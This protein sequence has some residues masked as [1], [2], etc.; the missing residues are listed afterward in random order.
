[1]EP[2]GKIS[3][4]MPIGEFVRF[5]FGLRGVYLSGGQLH[6]GVSHFIEPERTPKYT[7]IRSWISTY[8]T[9]L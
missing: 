8:L 5:I 9:G 4:Y 1:M 2:F 7:P 3:K 6:M